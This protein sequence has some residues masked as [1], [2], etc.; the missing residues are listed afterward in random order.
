M[1]PPDQSLVQLNTR[2]TKLEMEYKMALRKREEEVASAYKALCDISSEDVELLKRVVPGIS[3]IKELTKEDLL[4]NANGEVD[5]L[6]QVTAD[7]RAYVEHRL[8]FYEDQL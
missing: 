2:L 4:N 7:L 8:E 3:R 6:K 5:F 1:A